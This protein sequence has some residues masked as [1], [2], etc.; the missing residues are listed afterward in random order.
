MNSPHFHALQV[1]SVVTDG[2]DAK[3]VRFNVPAAVQ[4]L[5]H[6]EPGQYLTLR[7]QELRRSYSICA[8]PG[9]ALCVGVRRVPG[10]QFSSWLHTHLKAGDWLDVMPPDG[11]FGAALAKGPRHVLAVAGGSGIT[12]IMAMLQAVLQGD[13]QTRCTLIYGNRTAGSTMFRDVLEDLKNRYVSRLAFHVVLSREGVD[14][15]LH[16]GRID[17]QKMADFLK[18]SGPV[19]AAF[20]CGPHAMNDVVERALL[21]AGVAP[22][23]IHIERFG[24]PPSEAD[25]TLHA[26][27]PGDATQARVIIVRDGVRR[28]IAFA[29]TDDSILAAAAR[30]G[31]DVPYSCRSGVCATCRAKVLQGQVRMDRNFALQPDEVAAGYVLTCQAHP[32]SDVVV[33]SFD[34]R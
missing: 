33:V 24:V 12:P 21:G 3:L 14:S 18:L 19:D 23:H 5:F 20:V 31:L 28:E 34:E 16:S 17:A 9:Q 15:P 32:L 26:P 7:H 27:K 1:A 11:R 22:E 8:A 13:T 6:F 29:P 25:A 10:G 2:E 4:H 30:T